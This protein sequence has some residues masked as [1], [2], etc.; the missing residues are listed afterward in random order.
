MS[1][2]PSAPGTGP[3]APSGGTGRE[4]PAPIRLGDFRLHLVPDAEFALDGGAMFGVVPKALWNR[5]KRCDAENRIPMATNCLL[6][7]SGGDLVLIDTGLGDRLSAREREQFAAC[8]E[9]PRLP[10]RIRAAGFDLEDVT[11]VVLTHLHFDH[12]GWNCRR[13]ASGLVPT[14]PRA[15][16]WLARGE[17][18]HARRRSERDAPSYRPE[19]WEPLFAAGAVE[20]FDDEVVPIAGVRAVRAPGHN[21]DMCIVLLD[22]GDG[23]DGARG[24]FL[25]DLVPQGVHVPYP[26]IMSFDLYPVETM[27]SKRHWIPELAASGALCVFEHDT[28]LPLGRIVE[29]AP[30]RFR[31]VPLRQDV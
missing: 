23:G 28:D 1:A 29:E 2:G 17:V 9:G 22:G 16:Y 7:E 26:W 14:F 4:R 13:E 25:A 6:V 31:A 24:A 18:E 10:D 30:G 8:P 27:A 20:L 5:V 12:C 11:H 3:G 15:R 21:R 19:N